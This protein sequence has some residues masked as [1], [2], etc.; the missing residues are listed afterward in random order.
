M[1]IQPTLQRLML[2]TGLLF[3]F[4]V[5]LVPINF[6]PR[7]N[8]FSIYQ[9]FCYFNHQGNDA[10]RMNPLFHSVTY[11]IS[12]YSTFVW[13][14]CVIL[15]TGASRSRAC[16]LL[17]YLELIFCQRPIFLEH[18]CTWYSGTDRAF[19]FSISWPEARRWMLSITAKRCKNCDMPFR[20]SSTRCLVPVLSCRMIMLGYTWLDGKHIYCRSASAF[21]Q[22][23][24]GG[25]KC[26][27]GSNP[28]QQT[29][30]IQG[31]KS[32]SHGMTNF[33]IPVVN[34][35]KNSSTLAVSVAINL[36]IKLG[37][38]SVNGL[39]ESYSVDALWILL[40]KLFQYWAI[41]NYSLSKWVL[42][43][44]HNRHLLSLP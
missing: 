9:F 28:R 2:Q 38:V 13:I 11:F 5:Y 24:R 14:H 20:T 18:N 17:F 10:A 6:I 22:W 44:H 8:K 16:A 25:D 30:T 40:M 42:P 3:S 26:H 34:M 15:W 35:L 1:L 32:W 43:G 27:S 7:S 37:F 4:L 39:R 33:S 19:S 23:Q 31:Y 21:S 36:F 12:K 29:S 41:F